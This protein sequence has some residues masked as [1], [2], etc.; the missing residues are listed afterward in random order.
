MCSLGTR[1]DRLITLS[2]P[3]LQKMTDSI[4]KCE[5]YF[6]PKCKKSILQSAS[7]FLLQNATVLLQN[8][9]FIAQS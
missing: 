1:Y 2:T 5:S 3:L 8:A 7:V 9:T 4:T 6:I